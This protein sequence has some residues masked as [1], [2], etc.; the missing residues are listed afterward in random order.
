MEQ[1]QIDCINDYLRKSKSIQVVV[2][3]KMVKEACNKCCSFDAELVDFPGIKADVI[4]GWKN[5][6][7]WK[8]IY[9]KF[10]NIKVGDIIEVSNDGY[11]KWQLLGPFYNC[12]TLNTDTITLVGKDGYMMG[13]PAGL[14]QQ[15]DGFGNFVAVVAIDHE[16]ACNGSVSKEGYMQ[17]LSEAIDDWGWFE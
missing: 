12:V 1:K 14:T 13:H 2:T 10:K 16:E 6:G 15:E 4:I 5:P 7:H 8:P 9:T 11:M 17:L 3:D